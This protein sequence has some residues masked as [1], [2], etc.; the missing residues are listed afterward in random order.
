MNGIAPDQPCARCV[1]LEQEVAALQDQ[2]AQ[3]RKQ[4]KKLTKQVEKK[5]RAAKRQAAPFR[6]DRK[7]TEQD[8]KKS[9]RKS[10][11]APDHRPVPEKVDQVVDVPVGCCPDCQCQPEN[12][13]THTQYQT[14]IPPVQPVVTQFNVQV[15]TCPGCGKRVQ[16][17]HDEQVSQALGAA[18]KVLGPRAIATAADL[19]YR[20]G[21][22]FRKVSDLFGKLFDLDCCAG[23]LS[24]ATAR[25]ARAGQGVFHALKLQLPGYPTVHADETSWWIGGKKAWL[26]AFATENIVLF[27]VGGR[28]QAVALDVLGSDFG[29]IV[30]CDGYSVYDIFRT[31]RCNAHPLRRIRDLL[32]AKTGDQAAL[33]EIQALLRSGL[34]LRDRREELTELG[35][36]RL[37]TGVKSEVHQWIESHAEDDEES[38][39]RLARH[40]R[41][42]EKEFL[43]YLD[44]PRIPA[45]N[46]YGEGVL[47]FAVLLRKVGCCNRTETGVFTF[48][49]LSSLLATFEKRGKDFI[50]WAKELLCGSSPKYVPPDLLPHDFSYKLLL[51]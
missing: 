49:V 42:Y 28:D 26:H 8:R 43:I 47:R 6:R 31:A 14:D 11:H 33:T 34:S 45:T 4:V 19:K 5:S 20:L 7:K 46:N 2:T 12:I 44:D 21:I 17:R 22:P 29:G 51:D 16:G 41:R 1:E 30:C 37:A 9:G 27:Q 24:R 48:E 13:T 35:F 38:V 15:G 40:L 50:G 3:L 39:G 25:L 36:K 18:G 23:G 32:E 10:G